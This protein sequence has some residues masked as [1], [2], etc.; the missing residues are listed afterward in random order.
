[1]LLSKLKFAFIGLVAVAIVT[2]GAGVVAQDRPPEN[3]RLKNL[4]LKMDR[5]LEAFG[6]Q[7]QRGPL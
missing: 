6:S 2:T 3:D 7:N 5:L 4:E 1:M